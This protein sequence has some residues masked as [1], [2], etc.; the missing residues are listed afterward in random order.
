VS[1]SFQ[2]FALTAGGNV[3]GWEGYCSGGCPGRICPGSVSFEVSQK[4]TETAHDG[5]AMLI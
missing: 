2:I 4:I 5:V 3:L 1:A